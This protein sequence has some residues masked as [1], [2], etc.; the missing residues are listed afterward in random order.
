M[1]ATHAQAGQAIKGWPSSKE[2]QAHSRRRVQFIRMTKRDADSVSRSGHPNDVASS[3]L[4]RSGAVQIPVGDVS[5]A[6]DLEFPA[7]AAG[8]VLFAHGS[9]SSRHSP[10]NQHVARVLRAAGSGTLLF[11]LLTREEEA[12]DAYSGH[13]R[14]DIAFLAERLVAASRWL[15]SQSVAQY[16][17]L[18]YFGSSTG[19]GAALT[20]AALLGSAIRAVVSRGGRPDLAMEALPHVTAATLLIVGERDEVVL[21]LNEEA[22]ARLAVEKS[23]AVVPGATHLFEEPG[24]LEAVAR[25]AAHW[26]ERHWKERP[27]G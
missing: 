1:A 19:A 6:G 23:L 5:L 17:P 4:G 26:F 11:D 3:S 21:R 2:R 10:R 16:L 12:E 27:A 20:A 9:G 13:L 8:L 22:F 15:T 24:A 25:L 14:F 18:G 7:D